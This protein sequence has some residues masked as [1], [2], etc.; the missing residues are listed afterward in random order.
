MD[1]IYQL[2]YLCSVVLH[3][4]DVYVLVSLQITFFIQDLNVVSYRLFGL[5]H[6]NYRPRC[7]RGNSTN[8]V[9]IKSLRGTLEMLF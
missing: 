1:R 5:T 3:L 8:S 4:R 7:S 9:V 2:K 6:Q